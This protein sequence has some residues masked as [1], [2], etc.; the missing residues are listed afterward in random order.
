MQINEETLHRATSCLTSNCKKKDCPFQIHKLDMDQADQPDQPLP[1]CGICHTDPP[2]NGIKLTCGHI[3]CYLCIKSA[4]EITGSCAICRSEIPH[5]FNFQEHDILGAIKAP[6]SR[7]GHYWFYEGYRGWWLYD[8]ETNNELEEAFRRGS[9]RVVKF[10]AGGP[11]VIDLRRMV[12]VRQD[13]E[14]GRARRIRRATLDL[15]NILG[16]AGLKGRDFGDTL[17]MLREAD[18]MPPIRQ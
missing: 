6:T 18:R 14:Q 8:A 11:Y 7:D 5:E 12:Q 13:D 1:M 10:I 2:V 3:F 9:T 15:D 4:S 16:M 17:Q